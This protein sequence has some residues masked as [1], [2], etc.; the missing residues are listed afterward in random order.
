MKVTFL[1][2]AVPLTKT[3]NMKEGQIEK[4]GHPRILD[5]TSHF[6]DVANLDDLYSAL[7]IHA[8][9]NH[10]FLKGNVV[11]PLFNEPRAGTTNPNDPTRILLLDF[12]GLKGVTTIDTSLAHLN[13]GDVDHIVQYSSSSG[14]LP[15]RGLS[16]HVFFILDKE[17]SPAILKQW[18]THQN[19][20]VPILKQNLALTR[21]TNSLRWPLD[22]TTCQ[23]DKLIYI[24][25]PILGPGV[26][27]GFS[28]ERI[29]LIKK[30]KATLT[31]PGSIPNAEANKLGT[32]NA[33]NEQR[34]KAGLAK[35][36]KITYKS[37][38]QVEYMVNPDKAFVTGVRA[39]RGFVYLNLNGGDSWGYYHPENNPEYIFNFKNE[40]NYKTSELV[41]EYWSEVKNEQKEIKPDA[42]GNL[43]L[44]FRDFRTSQY[45]NGVFKATEG[46]L[47]IAVAKGKE[48]INDF[49]RSHGQPKVDPVPDWHVEF[50]PHNVKIVD[51]ENKIVNTFQ[52]TRFMKMPLRRVTTIPPLIRRII[53]HALGNDEKVLEH[54]MNWL[55]VKVKYRTKVGT[56]WVWHG[57]QGTGKGLFM[58]S[59]LRPILG[60]EYVVAMGM[61]AV[62]SSFNGFMEKALI[63]WIDESQVT[64]ARRQQ[65]LE[66]NLKIFI[67]EPT[68]SIRRMHTNAYEVNNYMDI[69]F[70][71]NKGDAVVI[72]PDDRRYNVA[73]VQKEILEITSKEIDEGIPAELEDFY[74]YLM[75]READKDL[76]RKAM[77][78][79]SKIDMSNKT[80]TALELCV[81]AYHQGNF[82]FFWNLQSGDIEALP[83]VDR[84]LA[85]KYTALLKEIVIEQPR[86]LSR[87]ELHTVFNF[88]V[89][90]IAPATMK[91]T[92]ILGHRDIEIMAV[93]RKGKTVRGVKTHWVIPDELRDQVLGKTA[94]KLPTNTTQS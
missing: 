68:I 1:Q 19:L 75:T 90:G 71:S 14:V 7:Q 12:D 66:A 93:N 72:S 86:T 9:K 69:I 24:A 10:C 87:E 29:Q 37:E 83:S 22:I 85:H 48:Q 82:M 52:P 44:A 53:M 27:D 47:K 35:K 20:T 23:N 5:Y 3:F 30:G 73:V 59:V 16:A 51:V 33:L 92:K 11:R 80:R 65:I 54:F 84:T 46:T 17:T 49:L 57:I 32:E 26:K 89:G 18:L 38:G 74:M 40:P 8:S 6:V 62:D 15:E 76:G 91:F 79:Q 42:S 4:I 70:A 61:D 36:T 78:N 60:A 67:T 63:L 88:V 55:A 31:L 13:L 50:N 34:E 45:Y 58:N 25:P 43:Y 41:P 77:K 64:E 21:T 56:A 81:E 2:A 39:E 28:G 94:S